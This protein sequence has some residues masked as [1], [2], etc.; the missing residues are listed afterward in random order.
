V[1][2]H[3]VRFRFTEGAGSGERE[4]L[5]MALSG[6]VD[7]IDEVRFLR[8]APSI[9]EPDVLAL[10]SGFDDE[11]GLAVYRDSP[12]H[13][14]VVAR[15]RELCSEVVRLDFVTDDPVDALPPEPR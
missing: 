2:W 7:E 14:P 9:D 6:L 1:L 15:A 11:A 4:E 3:I 12:A 5:A 13:L 10:L 8:V